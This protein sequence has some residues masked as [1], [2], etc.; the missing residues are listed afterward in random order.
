M[1]VYIYIYIY[2]YIQSNSFITNPRYNEHSVLTN[3][4]ESPVLISIRDC[5]ILLGYNDLAFNERSHIKYK[6]FKTFRLDEILFVSE[7]WL[8]NGEELCFPMALICQASRSCS[9]N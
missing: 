3:T 4:I 5:V 1:Y 2:I 6:I 7:H 9:R 8:K